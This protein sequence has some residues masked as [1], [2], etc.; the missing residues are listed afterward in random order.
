MT[1][2]SKMVCCHEVDAEEQT[3]QA[4]WMTQ[5]SLCLLVHV[6]PCEDSSRPAIVFSS[7]LPS[8]V[9]VP[10]Y[11]RTMQQEDSGNYSSN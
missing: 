1:V 3:W 10:I 9:Q 2:A 5:V 8:L 7:Y 4:S 6:S 11:L